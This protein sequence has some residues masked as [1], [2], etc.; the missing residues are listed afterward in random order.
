MYCAQNFTKSEK[1]VTIAMNRVLFKLPI[2]VSDIVTARA[3]VVNIR[4]AGWTCGIDLKLDVL[5]TLSF[6]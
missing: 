6:W 4:C 1:M 5:I 2:S 3:R